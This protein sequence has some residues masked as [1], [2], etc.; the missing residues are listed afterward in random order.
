MQDVV[1]L[2]F[3]NSHAWSAWSYGSFLSK[4]AHALQLLPFP[5]MLSLPVIKISRM[6]TKKQV[7]LRWTSSLTTFAPTTI[8]PKR[9]DR[10]TAKHYF[11]PL[12]LSKQLSKFKTRWRKFFLLLFQ[13]TWTVYCFALRLSREGVGRSSQTC[14]CTFPP[15]P[16]TRKMAATITTTTTRVYVGLIL[17]PV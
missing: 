9:V 5:A 6:R 12:I 11:S 13:K 16:S 7:V 10:F 3:I 17:P 14:Y 8:S 1:E 4:F 15:P 2:V